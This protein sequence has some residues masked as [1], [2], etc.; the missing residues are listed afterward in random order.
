MEEYVSGVE[1]LGEEDIT[2]AVEGVIKQFKTEAGGKE[3]KVGD[4]LKA[5]FKPEVLGNKP[6]EKGDV[7]R[8]VKK[9]LK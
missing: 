8:I 5:V 1:V 3:V 2:S 7:A 6:V 9:L 4:V